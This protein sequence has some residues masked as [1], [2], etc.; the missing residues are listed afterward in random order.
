MFKVGYKCIRAKVLISLLWYLNRFRTLFQC[1]NCWQVTEQV[2]EPVFFY[3]YQIILYLNIYILSTYLN[4][5]SKLNVWMVNKSRYKPHKIK[6]FKQNLKKNW[7]LQMALTNF[8]RRLH[9]EAFGMLFC[10]SLWFKWH[11]I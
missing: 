1:F 10:I 11:H 3:L 8:R 7:K 6:Y 4:M 9:S 2:F 5:C